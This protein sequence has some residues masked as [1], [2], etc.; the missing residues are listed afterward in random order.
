MPYE[1]S[2]ILMALV[3]NKL[4]LRAGLSTGFHTTKVQNFSV[5]QMFSLLPL[6]VTLC[7]ETVAKFKAAHFFNS[8]FWKAFVQ[9]IT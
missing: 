5:C 2:S 4:L 1:V 7:D 6:Y 9:M 8:F 3:H